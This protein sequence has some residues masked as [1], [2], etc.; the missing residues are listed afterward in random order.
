MYAK[1]NLVINN[2]LAKVDFINIIIK[3]KMAT[4]RI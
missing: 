3:V 4:S 2:I 1:Y